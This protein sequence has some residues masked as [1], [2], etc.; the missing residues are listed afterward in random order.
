MTTL[1]NT[2]KD[3]TREVFVSKDGT[4][5]AVV[6]E[7]QNYGRDRLL[8]DSYHRVEGSHF[9]NA[10]DLAVNFYQEFSPINVSLPVK[11]ETPL[12]FALKNRQL[13]F[14]VEPRAD[15]VNSED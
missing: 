11:S 12:Y 9:M 5:V 8:Y 10:S 14:L 15:E 2:V 7:V 4:K 1:E 3:P 6:N 13:P